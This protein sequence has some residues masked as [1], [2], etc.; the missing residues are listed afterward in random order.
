[1]SWLPGSLVGRDLTTAHR[2]ARL[3]GL[4]P[5]AIF[6]GPTSDP[7]DLYLLYSVL[8]ARTSAVPRAVVLAERWVWEPDDGEQAG[9]LEALAATLRSLTADTARRLGCPAAAVLYLR[10]FRPPPEPPRVPGVAVLVSGQAYEGAAELPELSWSAPGPAQE[11]TL[12]P[13][14]FRPSVDL[15]LNR[16]LQALERAAAEEPKAARQASESLAR[17]A[18]DYLK[19]APARCL[20]EGPQVAEVARAILRRLPGYLKDTPG[21]RYRLWVGFYLAG[22]EV[23][24]ATFGSRAAASADYVGQLLEKWD[25]WTRKERRVIVRGMTLALRKCYDRVLSPEDPLVALALQLPGSWLRDLA[26]GRDWRL[27]LTAFDLLVG[28][29]R[30]GHPGARAVLLERFPWAARIVDS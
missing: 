21:R 4:R 30:L 11:P 6:P 27:E 3:Y 20:V 5:Y 2:V 13:F 15:D 10:Y 26:A 7:R 24:A 22:V 14:P 19:E 25:G 17:Q 16:W 12:P 9:R 18:L 1:M 28:L 8:Y 23:T 29:H